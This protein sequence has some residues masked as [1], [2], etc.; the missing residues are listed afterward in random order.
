MSTTHRITHLIVRLD[1][2]GAETSLLRLI[3][4]TR[5]KLTH[6][7]IC[8]GPPT[9]LGQ[10]IENLGVRVSWLNYRRRG[11]W[12]LWQA[13][14]LLRRHPPDILQG[15]MYYGNVLASFLAWC[16]R[17]S[18]GAKSAS[19]AA[20]V[21]WNVRNAIVEPA[22]DSWMI[23]SAIACTRWC[24]PD[25]VI[26]NSFA[27]QQAHKAM[28]LRGRQVVIPNGINLTEFAPDAKIRDQVRSTYHRSSDIWV[29]VIA[30]WHKG[31]GIRE[32]L[33]A[34]KLLRQHKGAKARFFLAGNGLTLDHPEFAALLKEVGLAPCELD[35][36]GPIK[37]VAGFLPAVDLL[38]LPSLREGTPNILLEAMACGVN[39][40]ATTVGD[41]QRIVQSPARQ[42]VPGD[43]QDL[44]AKISTA[45][46]ETDKN[47]DARIMQE[48]E[49]LNS[50]YSAPMCM[51]AYCD[52]YQN[53]LA[54]SS[55]A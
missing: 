49:F 25:L 23:R 37:N 32:Y 38:V 28:S 47:R 44:A 33:E 7:V 24:H 2:G 5:E 34:V 52:H 14:R 48:R 39:T 53:L 42:V 31:K 6:H 15:W 16:L 27:G 40:V 46:V 50:N 54:P 18:A 35:L 29:G 26:Y 12:V 36:L 4:G 8:F 11:P 17:K 21:A 41:A 51:Q 22:S 43:V 30:R 55:H 3:A 10:E 9:A 1:T 19:A 20:K 45:M 13:F